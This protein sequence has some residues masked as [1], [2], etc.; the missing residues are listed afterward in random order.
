MYVD[1]R[2][3]QEFTTPENPQH[4]G[5]VEQG[6]ALIE[7]NRPAAYVQAVP[8]FLTSPVLQTEFMLAEA[9]DWSYDAINWTA[10]NTN[11]KNKSL[12]EM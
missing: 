9:S 4:N 6:L 2:I 3:K 1:N 8:L 5:V 10:S 12:Y 11:P 7:T